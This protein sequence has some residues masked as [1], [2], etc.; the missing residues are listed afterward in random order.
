MIT[1]SASPRRMP[2]AARRCSDV[3]A[4]QSVPITNAGIFAAAIAAS[5]RAPRSPLPW[6]ASPTPKSASI[7]RKSGSL[8]SGVAH[9]VTGPMTAAHAV[10]TARATSRACNEA[11]PSAPSAGMSRVL[12]KPGSG[13]LASTAIATGSFIA[14]LLREL[15]RI[16]AKEIGEPQPPHQDHCV[17][18]PILFPAPTGGDDALAQA[19]RP[20]HALEA[21]A[22]RDV[23]HQRDCGKPARGLEGR[24]THEHRLIAGRNPGE[25]RAD[26]HEP[27]DD[28]QQR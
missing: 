5:I 6:R 8:S 27:G 18:Y 17:D 20:A 13:A 2:A 3:S 23:F 14:V 21:L 25:P 7:A 1:A 24:A 10:A 15:F 4:G 22:E 26:V 12:A 19:Q 16:G 11:A 9:K 28:A